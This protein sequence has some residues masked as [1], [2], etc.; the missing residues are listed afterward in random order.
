M[1]LCRRSRYKFCVPKLGES[2]EPPARVMLM[3]TA[4]VAGA[5]LAVLAALFTNVGTQVRKRWPARAPL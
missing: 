5:V 4:N 1:R 2:A 3:D